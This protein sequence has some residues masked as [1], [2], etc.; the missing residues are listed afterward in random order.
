MAWLTMCGED[1]EGCLDT[2]GEDARAM[3]K[4]GIWSPLSRV[5][6]RANP[7]PGQRGSAR[8]HCPSARKECDKAT[9][10]SCC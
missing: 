1:G 4:E 9:G 8:R 7:G 6:E 3:V 5:E 2:S 10:D